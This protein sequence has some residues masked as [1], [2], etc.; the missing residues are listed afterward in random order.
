MLFVK[1]YTVKILLS[2]GLLLFL[3]FPIDG[4]NIYLDLSFPHLFQYQL[5]HW[6]IKIF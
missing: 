1:V 3:F 4:T 2:S 5:T 6:E